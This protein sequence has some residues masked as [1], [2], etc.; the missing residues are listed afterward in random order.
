MW[1]R[2]SSIHSR[3]PSSARAPPILV[4]F[5]GDGDVHWGYGI[6]THGQIDGLKKTCTLILSSLE[7]L[8]DVVEY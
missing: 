2:I 6:L 4:Y 1:C 8:A 7:D 5:S 3:S